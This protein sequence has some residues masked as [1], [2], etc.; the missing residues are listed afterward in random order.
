M[1]EVPGAMAVVRPCEPLALL[2]VAAAVLVE[3]Q[4]ASVVTVWV[5]PS[6]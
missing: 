4:V 6:T 5:D 1:V 3:A 2:T